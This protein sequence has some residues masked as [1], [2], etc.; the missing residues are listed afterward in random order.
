[1]VAVPGS[2]CMATYDSR[3]VKASLRIL[4][5]L[6]PAPRAAIFP[7]VGAIGPLHVDLEQP[8]GILYSGQNPTN[9]HSK[10]LSQTLL[11]LQQQ[12]LQQVNLHLKSDSS[13]VSLPPVSSVAYTGHSNCYLYD[14]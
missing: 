14:D 11:A 6:G 2:M 1:M 3:W 12:D 4:M 9:L 13:K 8:L 5:V 10:H 7:S